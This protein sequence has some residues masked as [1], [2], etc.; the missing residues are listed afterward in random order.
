MVDLMTTILSQVMMSRSFGYLSPLQRASVIDAMTLTVAPP[1][2]APD[3]D[4][5]AL[6][7][8]L[9]ELPWA[10][11]PRVR[12]VDGLVDRSGLQLHRLEDAALLGPFARGVARAV[13][14]RE[15]RES[16]IRLMVLLYFADGGRPR[17]LSTLSAIGPAMGIP[18]K[19]TAAIFK[20][21]TEALTE[22]VE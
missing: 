1:E 5:K 12:S 17:G 21:L 14:D 15:L 22:L 3:A 9:L 7:R 19:R 20:Q 6:R 18:A 13:R 10:W 11:E 16:I 4:R 8:K 2:G